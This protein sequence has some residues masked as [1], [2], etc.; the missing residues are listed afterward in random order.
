MAILEALQIRIPD[1]WMAR[2]NLLGE[3]GPGWNSYSAPAPNTV[4]IEHAELFLGVAHSQAHP[5][6]VAGTVGDGRHRR[7]VY[8]RGSRSRRR[9]LNSGTAH[10]LFSHDSTD[11]M[12]TRPVSTDASGYT[13]LP[14]STKFGPTSMAQPTANPNQHFQPTERLFCRVHRASLLANGKPT[15]LAF[16]LP[17]MSCNRESE[18]TAEAT[19]KGFDS[20]IGALCRSASKILLRATPCSTWPI[21][22]S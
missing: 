13:T 12:E 1:H 19:R 6:Q 4:A 7:D 2:L 21:S 8:P 9:V 5:S 14:F 16:D 15:L 11:A 22:R 3:L 10:V 20:K 17:D 18:S